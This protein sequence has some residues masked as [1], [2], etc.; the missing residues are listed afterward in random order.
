MCAISDI[1]NLSAAVL[2]SRHVRLDTSTCPPFVNA[3]WSPQRPHPML[4]RKLSE[5]NASLYPSF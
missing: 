3:F 4:P 1:S 2:D 5:L